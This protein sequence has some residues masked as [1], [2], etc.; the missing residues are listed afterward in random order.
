MSGS[1]S[2]ISRRADAT[3]NRLRMVQEDFADETDQVREDYLG[4]EIE[5]ALKQIAPDQRQAFL[6]ELQ[7]RFPSWDPQVQVSLAG[8]SSVART[9]TDARELQDPN[10]LLARLIQL[11]PGLSADDRRVLTERLREAGLVPA[12]GADWPDQQRQGLAGEIQLRDA[13]ALDLPRALE[14]V[15][16]LVHFAGRLD[17]LVW[18]TWRQIA[19]RS[20]FRPAAP[21]RD[22]LRGFLRVDED[23]SAGQ[24]KDD[25]D[26]LGGLVASLTSAVRQAGQHAAQYFTRLSPGEVENMVRLEGGS[27][28]TS[29][30]VKCW[31]KYVDLYRGMDKDVVEKDVTAA[32]AAH[33]EAL[34]KGR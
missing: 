7:A 1:N 2:D 19:P 9:A 15:R 13:D 25:L 21:L 12:G 4:E 6:Q 3:A 17:R 16:L 31:S 24:V 27:I 20:M 10:F 26:R 22:R 28:F 33:V 8:E 29:K 34:L 23:V 30:E 18:N 5:R 14:L 11:A 32:V